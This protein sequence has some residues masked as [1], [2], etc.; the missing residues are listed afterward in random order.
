MTMSDAESARAARAQMRRAR[1]LQEHINLLG[2]GLPDP[3]A[4]LLAAAR[5][6]VEESEAI[7]DTHRNLNRLFSAID[8]LQAVV[9]AAEE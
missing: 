9:E 2:A 4:E 7:D 1:A 3:C 8:A 5:A 6:V